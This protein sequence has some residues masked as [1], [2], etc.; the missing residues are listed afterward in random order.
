MTDIVGSNKQWALHVFF[1]A[2]APEAEIREAAVQN[3]LQIATVGSSDE[4]AVAAQLHLPGP[5]A[6]RYA[7][8]KRPPGSNGLVL[9]PVE[10]IPNANSA[11]PKTIIKF[12]EWAVRAYPADK[13]MLVVWGH[14]Y[15]VDDYLPRGARPH[16]HRTSIAIPL[17]LASRFENVDSADSNANIKLQ[18]ASNASIFNVILD[19]C[20]HEVLPNAQVGVAARAC[21]KAI[22]KD[23]DI[24]GLDACTMAMAEVWCE[25][26]HC[27][28]I[29]IASE[30]QEPD[31][32]FPYDRFLARLML[33][34]NAS[35]RHVAKMRWTPMWSRMRTSARL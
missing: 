9:A 7:M 2:N 30:A 34:P 16:F 27:A 21:K 20:A 12:F 33:E 25:L 11:D 5:W 35:P 10:T 22:N 29:G 15:G 3:L 13:T 6:Y 17:E 4:I 26:Q 28:Q 1:G 32:S 24:L 19:E 14:G 23:L 8:P 18:I 31:A